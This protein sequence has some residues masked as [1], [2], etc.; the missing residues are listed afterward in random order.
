L[1]LAHA[2]GDQA[3]IVVLSAGGAPNN[4]SLELA[5]Q[6]EGVR[7]I[8]HLQDPAL[9]KPDFLTLGVV[10]AEAARHLEACV[11]FAGE[12]SEGEGLGMVPAALAHHLGAPFF[13]RVQ[14][15]AF[16]PTEGSGLLMTIRSGGRLCRVTSPVPAVLTTPFSP[17]D[18]GEIPKQSRQSPPVVETLSLAQLGVDASR[19]VPRPDLLGTLVPAHA[20]IV[21]SKSFDEAARML[22][23]ER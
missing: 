2:L 4:A 8:V 12:Y 22:L 1:R 21:R 19:L 16:P 5:R 10:L 20:E 13:A 6:A 9:S 3:E 17:G 7:R 15:V 23:R 11:V 18:A 14:S